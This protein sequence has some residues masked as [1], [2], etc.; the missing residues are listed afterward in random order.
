VLPQLCFG[1]KKIISLIAVAQLRPTSAYTEG[2]MPTS[3]FHS[4]FTSRSQRFVILDPSSKC[5]KPEE[6]S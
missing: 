6:P 5:C 2:L 3:T 4:I 1:K